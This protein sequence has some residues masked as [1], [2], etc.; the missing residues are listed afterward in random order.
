M[1]DLTPPGSVAHYITTIVAAHPIPDLWLHMAPNDFK[2]EAKY[3]LV[4]PVAN[5]E[6]KRPFCETGFRYIYVIMPLRVTVKW[7]LLAHL[8]TSHQ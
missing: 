4:V 5:A 3:R 2:I 8:Q 1:G 7:C 6:R